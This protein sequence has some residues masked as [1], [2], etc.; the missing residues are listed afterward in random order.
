[1]EENSRQ[2]KITVF[3]DK[4]K[5][6]LLAY[7]KNL[8]QKLD[9]PGI[10]AALFNVMQELITN[11]IKANLKRIFFTREGY[12]LKDP[13]QYQKGLNAFKVAYADMH[14]EDWS[15]ALKELKLEVTVEVDI[16]A[17]RLLI[18]V[19]NNTPMI[20]EE[21]KRV[22][23]NLAAAMGVKDLVQFSVQYGDE[24]E[25][26][27]LGL[28]MVILLIKDMG[29]DPRNFRV[30]H[31]RDKTVARLEFPLSADY[32]TIREKYMRGRGH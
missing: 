12:S 18:Y 28:A 15:Q 2:F 14:D 25:G 24:S 8:E 3:E 16:N 30:F 4:Q 10:S 20:E 6:E 21:E 9:R 26:N 5:E 13:E 17:S 11:A 32:T 27:G 19:H 22:R 1:M 23:K 31:N 29:F 7:F